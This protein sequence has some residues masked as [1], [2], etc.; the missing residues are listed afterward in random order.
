MGIEICTLGRFSVMQNDE[1]LSALR[2]QPLRCALLVYLAIERDVTRDAVLALLW[3]DRETSS[4]R[5]SLSQTLYEL[6]RTL[7]DDWL[8]SHGNFLVPSKAVRIDAHALEAALADGRHSD[9]LGLYEGEFLGGMFLSTS[10]PFESWVSAK[11]ARLERLHRTARSEHIAQSRTRGDIEEALAVARVWIDIDPLEDEA[12]HAVISLL[13]EMGR[14]SEALKQYE[15]YS[16]L[17]AREL[18]VEPLDETKQ[19]VQEIRSGEGVG[20]GPLLTRPAVT[21]VR[22]TL[23]GEGPPKNSIAVVPFADIS[24]DAANEY[25]SNGITTEV[26]NALASIPGLRVLARSSSSMLKGRDLDARESG[27]LLNVKWLVEGEVQKFGDDLRITAQ[28]VDAEDGFQLWSKRFSTQELDDVFQLQEEIS[29]SIVEALQATLSLEGSDRLVAVSTGDTQAY[30]LYLAG[31]FNYEK[32]SA[33]GLHQAVLDFQK[34]LDLDPDFARAHSGLADAYIALSQFQFAAAADVLPKAEAAADRALELDPNLAAAH[35]SKAHVL[36]TFYW[37]WEAAEAGY[38]RALSLNSLWWNARTWYA[39]LLSALGRPWE[40][41]A[42]MKEAETLEPYSSPVKFQKGAQL[43]RARR[44]DLAIVALDQA[45]DL[46]PGYF[47]AMVFKAFCCIAAGQPRLAIEGM[48]KAIEEV[49]PIP[50]LQVPMGLAYVVEGDE[51]AARGVLSTLKEASK[52]CHVPALFKAAVHGALGDLDEACLALDEAMAE[53]YGQLIFLG[54]DPLWDSI[55]N[56]P[57]FQEY[58]QRMGLPRRRQRDVTSTLHS[59]TRS[60]PR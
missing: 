11:K 9:A 34:A 52:T 5:H 19:I 12:Q 54:V 16:E 55:E 1:E 14:R 13:A 32:R 38:L 20:A 21:V 23:L 51:K 60:D 47:A 10:A 41:L 26:R 33:D 45:L 17:L 24:P 6:R 56:E 18:D 37:R 53:R 59:D 44:Y 25:F 58:L 28:L 39:D 46:S 15:V 7:G 49:G 50:V 36:D 35:A 22:E 30:E 27:R 29:R 2:S 3:P 4:A 31:Q 40:G 48:A 42:Q 8:E 43:Y 57:R